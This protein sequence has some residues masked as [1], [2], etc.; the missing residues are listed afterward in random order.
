VRSGATGERH[1]GEALEE[2]L[3][4]PQLRG[5]LAIVNLRIVE[6]EQQIAQQQKRI[7]EL[8]TMGLPTVEEEKTLDMIRLLA[9]DMRDNQLMIERLISGSAEH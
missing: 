6:V 9:S 3:V 5:L 8:R 1:D 7:H 2:F 4:I